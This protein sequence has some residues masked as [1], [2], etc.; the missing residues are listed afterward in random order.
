PLSAA[1]LYV[2]DVYIFRSAFMEHVASRFL[3]SVVAFYFVGWAIYERKGYAAILSPGWLK[4]IGKI[5]YGVYLY[6]PF[7]ADY[8][9]EPVLNFLQGLDYGFFP[10]LRYNLYIFTVPIY[11]MATIAVSTVSYYLLEIHFLKLKNRFGKNR[12]AVIQR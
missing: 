6:H 2:V 1:G 3:I 12:A 10:P 5:S 8:L 11:T 7:V 9:N 4:Y